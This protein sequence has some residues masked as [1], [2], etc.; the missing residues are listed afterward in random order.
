MT[1][2]KRFFTIALA[3][4]S[5]ACIATSCGTARKAATSVNFPSVDQG[6]KIAI[7]AHRGFWNCEEAGFAQNSI[8]ALRL[9][10]E[11][12]LWGSEFDIQLTSDDQIVVNHDDNFLGK[13]IREH[14]LEQLR[15]FGTLK[16]GEQLPTLDE[17]LMQGKKSRTT[18]LVCELKEQ[19]SEE[20]NALLT[21]LTMEC[22]KKHGLLSPKRVVFISFSKQICDIIAR[23]YP[24][25]TNQ[26]LK[27][28]ITPGSLAADGVNGIDYNEKAFFQNP[29]FI[30]EAHDLSM[31]VNVW[32]INSEKYIREFISRGVDQITTNEP[33]LARSLLGEKE[34]K[35]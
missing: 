10:Q 8:A 20:R 22:L 21:S 16:N 17:Y 12:G 25:F 18:I 33:L 26:Y 28:N 13:K 2:M 24:K 5:I 32:T 23:E 11:N 29:G 30:K 19:R 6:G 7:V 27:G 35:N 31:S 3:A 15:S 14:T 9:A 1:L 34:F 4:V